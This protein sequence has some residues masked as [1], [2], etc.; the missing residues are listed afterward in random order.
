MDQTG[1]AQAT[2]GVRAGGLVLP[3]RRL[4]DG[5]RYRL[6]RVPQ[7][8]QENAWLGLPA[9]YPVMLVYVQL[10]CEAERQS[11]LWARR[12]GWYSSLYV[13]LGLPSAVLA[14]IAGATALASATGR[15]L[16]GIIALVSSALTAAV[17]AE[18]SGKKRDQAAVQRSW[19]DDLYDKI[20]MCR[21]TELTSFTVDDSS[22]QLAVFYAMESAARNGRDPE[23][24]ASQMQSRA[25][26]RED[27]PPLFPQPT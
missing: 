19:W 16:A 10:E 25:A 7:I 2:E 21:L 24:A 8:M 17:R 23:T 15:Y 13:A 26:G 4:R 20:H 5:Q 14:A 27:S 1:V 22:R 12:A 11:R 9:G 3:P 6:L 18:D